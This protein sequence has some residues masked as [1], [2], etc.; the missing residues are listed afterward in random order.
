MLSRGSGS[1]AA[2]FNF[3]AGASY[4]VTIGGIGGSINFGSLSGNQPIANLNSTAAARLVVGNLNTNTTYSGV[5]GS[6]NGT[7]PS[8]I[9]VSKVGTGTLTLTGQNMYAGQA[10]TNVVGTPTIVGSGTLIAGSSA[11]P[12][13]S[14][15]PFGPTTPTAAGTGPNYVL[16]GTNGNL[17]SASLLANPGMT[18]ANPIVSSG[19]NNV[20]AT[21][22]Y[23]LTLGGADAGTSTFSGAVTLENN[24]TIAQ[25]TGGQVNITGGIT[26]T[27]QFVGPDAVSV[28][29]T[30]PATAGSANNSG[31]QTVTFSGPG[32]MTVSAATNATNSFG[33]YDSNDPTLS[34]VNPGPVDG[35]TPQR[36]Q[37]NN[38]LISVVVTGGSTTFASANQYSGGT[39]VT[40]GQL[41]FG[42]LS[43]SLA[44]CPVTALNISGGVTQMATAP[45]H[46]A[47]NVLVLSSGYSIPSDA[48]PNPYPP[49]PV[50]ASALTIS[51]TGTLDLTNND[52]IVQGGGAS[53]LATINS[54][55]KSGFSGNPAGAWTG[56]GIVTSS[57]TIANAPKSNIGLADVLAGSTTSFDGQTVGPNDVIVKFTYFG[58]TNLDG[59]VNASDYIAT[60]NGFNA[61]SSGWQNG[62]FNYDGV[63]NGDDYALIDNAF[64]TQGGVVLNGISAGPAEMIASNT[65]QIAGASSSSVPEPTTLGM[66]G[67]GGAGLLM[68]RRRRA[69]RQ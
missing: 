55:L 36:Y 15:G 31:F 42:N 34:N 24:L 61:H 2:Q 5:I 14:Y 52:M 21:T 27:A 16:L 68:R 25:P 60:D 32:S 6:A 23:T 63:I 18:V 45:S 48:P 30:A 56:T 50:A 9:G 64:N 26:G 10:M 69:A 3:N 53:G 67:I 33:I 13:N 1:S 12:D 62:D 7:G 19:G 54:E 44:A 20:T 51:G 58:D 8:G 29:D 37:G 22:A 39:S 46:A 49:I 28:I 47:R 41:I 65:D 57:G 35:V 43:P 66:L 17:T 11:A 59:K 38:G 4:T 40:G